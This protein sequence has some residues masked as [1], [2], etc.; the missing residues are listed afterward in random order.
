MLQLRNTGKETCRPFCETPFNVVRRSVA[1]PS[2][3]TVYFAGEIFSV[4]IG[5]KSESSSVKEDPP[6]VANFVFLFV[7]TSSGSVP[8]SV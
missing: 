3:V 4:S 8:S 2:G 5:T 7:G 6:S 1:E